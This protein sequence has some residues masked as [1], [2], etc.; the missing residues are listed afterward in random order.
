MPARMS[1]PAVQFIQVG[2]PPLNVATLSDSWQLSVEID[3]NVWRGHALPHVGYAGV[4]LGRLVHLV[5][6][7]PQLSSQRGFSRG[8]WTD[9]GDPGRARLLSHIQSRTSRSRQGS[10]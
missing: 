8:A 4:F 1:Q 5:A 9:N 10:A 2:L 3:Q 6:M 7:S